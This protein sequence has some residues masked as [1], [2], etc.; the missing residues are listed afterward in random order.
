MFFSNLL[1]DYYR[2][3]NFALFRVII[4]R[5]TLNV[6]FITMYVRVLHASLCLCMCCVFPVHPLPA[7]AWQLLTFVVASITVV[8]RPYVP[9]HMK[10]QWK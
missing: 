3:F 9:L 8:D 10:Q 2:P 1:L 5:L 7:L 4:F 6:N